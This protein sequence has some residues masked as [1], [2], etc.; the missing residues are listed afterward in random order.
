MKTHARVVVIG[1][2]ITGC[3]TLYHLTKLGWRDVVLVE[4]DELTSGSTWHAAGNCPNFSMSWNMIKLQHYSTSLYAQLAE[5]TD[6]AINYHRTG[7]IR[8]AHTKARMEEF[9]HGC[10]MA[11]AIGIDFEML[12]PQEIKDR[13]PFVEVHDIRGGLWDPGD[14]DIDPSQVTQALARGA[15][16]GG[17]EIYRHN[18][19]TAISRTSAGEWQV[20]SKNGT[21]TCEIVV[22]AGGYRA[23]EVAA[24]VGVEH[25]IISMEHQYLVTEA[26]P[27]LEALGAQRLPLI[28]DPDVSYYLR[29]ERHGLILGPYERHCKA[30]GV[31][32]IP[33]DFGMD[34][35]DADLDRLEDYIE[36]A[37]ARMP[38]LAKAGIQRVINGPIPYTPDGF[39]LVGPVYPLENFHACAAFSFG[40]TQGGGAGKCAAELI[41]H[42]QSEWDTWFIDPRRYTG[43]ANKRYA[44][45]KA[46]ELYSREYD[47]A[48]PFEERP[49]G[50]PA[51]TTPLYHVL[52]AKGAQFG[53][54]GGWERAAW[55]APKGAEIEEKPSFHHT[56]WFQT[57]GEECRAVRE[58]VGVLDLGGFS[59]Y[60][61]NGP[62]AAAFLDRLICGRLPKVGRIGLAYF[63]TPRGGILSETTITRLDE[64][65][66]YLCSAAAAEWHDLHWM[67]QRQPKNAGFNISNISPQYGTLVLAGPRSREV[68]SRITEADL[69][70]QAFPWLSAREISV[71]FTRVL[72]LRV[73]YVGE[74]GWELHVPVEYQAPVYDSLMQAGA[75]FD[76]ADFGM[77]AMESLRLE[78]CYRAWKVDMTDEYTPLE[79]GLDRFID[80]HKMHFIGRDP[81]LAQWRK[82]VSQRLV[83]LL[84]DAD[85]ADAPVCA[86]VFQEDQNVGLVT[87]GGYGYSVGKSIAL[88]Y[89][90]ID[91]TEPGTELEVEI[92]GQRR[93][94]VVAKEPIYD[95]S[96]ARLRA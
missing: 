53:A 29:Q 13:C 49:A 6:N 35:F 33:A 7:S 87:S 5:E 56:N 82:G 70:N 59:K 89:V 19:V 94:A 71:G 65:R 18:P 20:H 21:I 78:K 45:E 36:D 43:Y 3:S 17:A 75:D 96:N 60:E 27:E 52:K 72:A 2:G 28:R 55:F 9:E 77:Y 46:V 48:F 26:V 88:A 84:V 73:N 37:M 39:P 92:L 41:V 8:L 15:R 30:W 80:L 63:C 38:I 4:R 22:N 16:E 57:V 62:G 69:S 23:N 40:I 81:L 93:R 50:R 42:G 85:D 64:E 86:S 74:L 10:A 68:L 34:L 1:G 31:D 67:Q 76:I 61:L 44:L 54:R 95:P 83:P 79:A 25:P 12:T 66:F 51:K 90:R 14:G 11:R 32:G 24:M 47:I 91:L 58:R